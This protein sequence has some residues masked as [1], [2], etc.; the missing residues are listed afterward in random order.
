MMKRA[1]IRMADEIDA[2]QARAEVARANGR[3]NQWV[4]DPRTAILVELGLGPRRV[5]AS[6]ELRMAD[7]SDAA[8]ARGE[9]AS[10][11][12]GAAIRDHVRG[13][14]K[15]AALD[16]LGLDRRRVAQLS[17]GSRS[18]RT[19]LRSGGAILRSRPP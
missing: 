16:D 9:V 1:E 7:E 18:E 10:R 11:K 17:A 14:D 12:D 2:A 15:V 6:Y 8:Q 5:A 13:T 4:S 3:V 19:V